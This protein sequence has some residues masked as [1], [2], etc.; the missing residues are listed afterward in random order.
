MEFEWTQL[1]S[2]FAIAATNTAIINHIKR[3]LKTKYPHLD[4][5]WLPYLSL[6]TGGA[7]CWLS[8]LNVFRSIATMP[9]P[10]GLG[11]TSVLVGGGAQLLHEVLREV[12]DA[13]RKAVGIL[14]GDGAE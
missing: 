9:H 13:L 8:D 11:L 5:W 7:I 14:A 4:L 1:V 10:L 6:L 12:R 3:P 2:V